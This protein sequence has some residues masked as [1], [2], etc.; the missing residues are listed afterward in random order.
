MHKKQLQLGPL[1]GQRASTVDANLGGTV[2]CIPRNASQS[3][4]LVQLLAEE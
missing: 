3:S 2:R 4:F 1:L